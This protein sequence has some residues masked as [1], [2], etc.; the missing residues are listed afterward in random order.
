MSIFNNIAIVG[1]YLDDINGVTNVGSRYAFDI[2]EHTMT[3]TV[4]PTIV[5]IDTEFVRYFSFHFVC[6]VYGWRW[7]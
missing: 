4:I 2:A 1:A 7:Y 6:H 5:P 3:P